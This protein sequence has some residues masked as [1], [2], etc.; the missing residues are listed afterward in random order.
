MSDLKFN[1]PE[2]AIFEALRE[3]RINMQL[4]TNFQSI[5][6]VRP[7]SSP[8]SAPKCPV[9]PFKPTGLKIK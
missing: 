5:N 6:R 8:R 7:S 2:Y 4:N 3:Q 9:N 1:P